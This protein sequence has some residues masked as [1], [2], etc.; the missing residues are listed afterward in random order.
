MR[1]IKL[2]NEENHINYGSSDDLYDL[3]C[4][5]FRFNKTCYDE[6]RSKYACFG[7]YMGCEPFLLPRI[8]ETDP[9]VIFKYMMLHYFAYGKHPKNMAK[10]RVIDFSP[11]EIVL[12]HDLDA[13]GRRIAHFYERHGYIAAYAVHMQ[14]RISH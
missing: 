11:D 13:L 4:Y 2:V 5:V 10:H 9:E 6:I 8:Y 1:Y 3:L 12:P 14:R 7:N